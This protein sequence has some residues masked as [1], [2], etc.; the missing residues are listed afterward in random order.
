MKDDKH[1]RAYVEGLRDQTEQ[2]AQN[3][4]R[5]NDKLRALAVA[6]ETENSRL[7]EQV[8]SAREMAEEMRAVRER[9]DTAERDRTQLQSRVAEMS[10]ELN[11]LRAD[12]AYVAEQLVAIERESRGIAEDYAAAMRQNSSLANLYVASYM[13]HSSL[14]RAEVLSGMA[15]IVVNIVGS[16]DY[17]VFERQGETLRVA[18]AL[19]S[20]ATALGTTELGAGAIGELARDGRVR[21]FDGTTRSIEAL[22]AFIPLSIGE[23]LIGAIAIFTLLPQKPAITEEDGEIFEMLAAHAATALYCASLHAQYGMELPGCRS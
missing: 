18:T 15:Q 6:V 23:Y 16:E 20:N 1:P 11:G 5:E 4:L 17:A 9:L 21:V 10:A 13:L 7:Q 22:N 3:L 14:D 12:R 19:G 8:A 2:Y